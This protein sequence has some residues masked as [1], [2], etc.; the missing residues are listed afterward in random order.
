MSADQTVKVRLTRSSNS[1]SCY[2]RV[3][4]RPTV[5]SATL[6][7]HD[8]AGDHTQTIT[9]GTAVETLYSAGKVQVVGVTGTFDWAELRPEST[10]G[11]VALTLW[12]TS[13]TATGSTNEYWGKIRVEPYASAT[14]LRLYNTVLLDRYTRGV[15]EIDPGWANA[16]LPSQYAP[17]CVKAQQTAARTYA[18]AQGTS[19]LCDNT[20]DQVY[21][22]YTYEASH[23]G[24]AAAAD[25][26]AGKVITYGGAPISALFCSHSGGYLT[27][28]AW[29][30]NPGIP[31]LVAKPDPW[32]LAAPQPPW[33]ISPGYPWTYS[34][35]PGSLA[36]KLGVSVGTITKVEVTARDTADPTSHARTLKITGT[37]GSTTMSARIFKSRLS[38]KSTLILSITGG[39]ETFPGATR[40]DDTDPHL[41]YA[42][43]WLPFP[44]TAAWGGGYARADSDDASVSIYFTGT[45]LDWITTKGTTTGKADVSLDGT[46]RTTVDLSTSEATYQ[47]DV[48]STGTLSNG[49]HVVTIKRSSTSPAG[50]F[51]TVDAVD[52]GGA[53]PTRRRHPPS[54]ALIPPR[55]RA[56]GAPRS[57]SPAPRSPRS[58]QSPSG[59]RTRRASTSTPPLG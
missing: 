24:V 1:N 47:V 18:V 36:S 41:V 46:F 40:F 16:S 20:S 9:A 49:P 33:T 23:P 38:L 2:Y 32:S 26:T 15:S 21:A 17:E 56:P 27:D 54:P 39:P 52:V 43:A 35:S 7:T 25:A 8:S 34:I 59:D 37:T 30:D 11:R 44:K 14:S 6:V 48:W 51:L 55:A 53:S 22:G 19:D 50:T 4:L 28:S 42:G 5:T 45:R 31:Y 13:S 12:A 58:P 10:N 29:S 3:V 57:S